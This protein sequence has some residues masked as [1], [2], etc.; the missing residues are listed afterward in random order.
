MLMRLMEKNLQDITQQTPYFHILFADLF[1][2]TNLLLQ[3]DEKNQE[4]D[5]SCWSNWR[6]RWRDVT[7]YNQDLI[8]KEPSF[9]DSTQGGD[10]EEQ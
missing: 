4:K 8:Q 1:K 5:K 10:R 9:Y 3:D 6:K 2:C 7:E